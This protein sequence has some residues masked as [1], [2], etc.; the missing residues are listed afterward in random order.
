MPAKVFHRRDLESRLPHWLSQ[1]AT[2]AA[3]GVVHWDVSGRCERPI[4]REM[5]GRRPSGK[6]AQWAGGETSHIEGNRMS[7]ELEV[8]CRQCHACLKAR[9]RL[10]R[11][12]AIRE[13]IAA[14]RT[15]FGTLTVKPEMR[16]LAIS[17]ARSLM[18]K[19]GID[20][21][22]LSERERFKEVH[23]ICSAEITRWLKRVRKQSA[24]K[25]RILAV[26][27][28]HKDGFPHYHVLIHQR[29][30]TVTHRQLNLT[31]GWGFSNF[32]LVQD[33]RAA[34]YVTKYLTKSS[35]TRVR[36]SLD[37]GNTSSEIGGTPWERMTPKND[38]FIGTEQD[39]QSISNGI[40]E[41]SGESVF[42]NTGAGLSKATG[43][44]EH[45]PGNSTFAFRER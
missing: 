45:E 8:A 31:W 4:T 39:G 38:I 2:I 40:S 16:F 35:L 26:A 6:S 12:R 25:I 7:V 33:I 30:G 5:T 20:F 10:W 34:F 14:E 44:S 27:E 29:G 17:K 43:A 1:G 3:P 42:A 18:G 28:A 21:D 13:T 15:W 24:A 9:A 41:P 23:G 11:G 19:Q 22:T 36:A 32:K 37:Y